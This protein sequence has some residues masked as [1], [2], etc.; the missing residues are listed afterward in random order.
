MY[1]LYDKLC[2][3]NKNFKKKIEYLKSDALQRHLS[4]TII[5][6]MDFEDFFEFIK[7]FKIV[8]PTIMSHYSIYKRKLL[9]PILKELF[10][11]PFK[12]IRFK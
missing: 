7:E 2:Y 10:V 6:C 8:D 9:K 3:N 11:N 4:N 1:S 5:E 12:K